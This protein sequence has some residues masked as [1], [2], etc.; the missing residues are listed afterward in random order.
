MEMLTSLVFRYIALLGG[1]PREVAKV[2]GLTP[3]AV[4]QWPDDLD[5]ERTDRVIGAAVR[6]GRW[7]PQADVTEP[8]SAGATG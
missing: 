8:V 6:L 3:Q 7:P 5:Q 2:L 4:Y 1:R